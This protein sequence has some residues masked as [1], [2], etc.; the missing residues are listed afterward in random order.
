[1][2][3]MM[4]RTAVALTGAVALG[5]AGCGSEDDYANEPRP[6]AP[7]VVTAAIT[8]DGV[9]VSPSSF[10]AGPISLI[11]TNQTDTSQRITLETQDASS[12]PGIRQSTG[13]INPR[14]TAT[15]K[16]DVP[17][18][19]YTVGVGAGGV[20]PATLEVGDERA[21]AQNDLLQP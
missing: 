18:G 13:P 2:T 16:A 1:M 14:D 7:I 21:S 12:G 15:L 6:P 20:E 10:G 8:K 5:A 3:S 19:T 17:E 9:S 4:R 11:V